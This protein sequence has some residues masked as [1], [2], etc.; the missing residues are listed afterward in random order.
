MDSHGCASISMDYKHPGVFLKD[1]WV[2]LGPKKSQGPPRTTR[3]QPGL[4]GIATNRR[5]PPET[6][7]ERSKRDQKETRERWRERLGKLLLSMCPPSETTADQYKNY[8][9]DNNSVCGR[10]GGHGYRGASPSNPL[11]DSHDLGRI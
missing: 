3:D 10:G 11:R 4:P 2:P 5:A 9:S 8:K 7:R 6:T 1:Y